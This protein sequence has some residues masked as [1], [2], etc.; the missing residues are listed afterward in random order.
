MGNMMDEKQMQEISEQIRARMKKDQADKVR[1][2]KVLNQVAK[3]GGILFT[4]SSLMEQ[5]TVT[6]FA[7]SAGVKE[8]VYNRG[9]GGFTTDDFLENMDT[10]IFDLEPS[11]VFI[12]IGTNDMNPQYGENWEE[13]LIGNLKAIYSQIKEKLPEAEVYLMAFYPVNDRE[14]EGEQ[15][16]YTKGM[17][18]IRT[19]ENLNRIN[20]RIAEL[21]E[22]YGFHFIDVNAGIKN[23]RGELKKEYTMEGIHMYAD[24]YVQVFEALKPYLGL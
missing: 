12:N 16:F 19:N 2:Y 11:R 21:A 8:P 3:R 15:A 9:I 17:F 4:G 22:E 6:E 20:G 13:R 23:E 1:N 10:Q 18:Q 7:M 14:V 24:G 5:F